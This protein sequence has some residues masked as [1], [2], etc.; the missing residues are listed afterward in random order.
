VLYWKRLAFF[1][2]AT[3][4]SLCSGCSP[5][6]REISAKD[7]ASI[8]VTSPTRSS[9]AIITNGGGTSYWLDDARTG[10][11]DAGRSAGADV[12]FVIPDTGTVAA[13]AADIEELL[14][15]GVQGI[16]ISPVDPQAEARL[17]DDTASRV[18]L[19]TLDSDAPG[20]QRLCYIGADNRAA[21]FKAA[22]LIRRPCRTAVTWCCLQEGVPDAMRE[23]G[24]SAYERDLPDH[25]FI[26]SRAFRKTGVTRKATRSKSFQ[27]GK[28]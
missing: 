6:T 4:I 12:T 16:A 24:S 5:G 21:G 20:T 14:A 15:R 13:Q 27:A 2:S 7:D 11:Y 9:I 8:A 17:L 23:Q 28:T 26:L 18:S 3:L 22:G 19:I 10:A 1:L 25:T